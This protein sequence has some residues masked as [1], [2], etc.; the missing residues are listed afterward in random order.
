[1]ETA[2]IENVNNPNEVLN[3][4]QYWIHFALLIYLTLSAIWMAC[5]APE[6]KNPNTDITNDIEDL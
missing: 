1:M 5:N 4:K 6:P 2:L 3:I